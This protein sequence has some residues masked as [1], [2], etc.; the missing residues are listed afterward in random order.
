MIMNYNREICFLCKGIGYIMI[1]TNLF[2]PQEEKRRVCPQCVG[3]GMMKI[4]KYPN[5]PNNNGRKPFY[6][7]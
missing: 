3:K 2:I 1:G 4:Y 5:R 6:S 7:L